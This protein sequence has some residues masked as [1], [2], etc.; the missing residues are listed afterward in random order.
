MF[1][2]I[3]SII[4]ASWDTDYFSSTFWQS[5][6]YICGALIIILAVT[7][8]DLVYRTFSAFWKK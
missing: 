4:N 1:D 2:L 7:F 8:I 3:D 6:T 5:G